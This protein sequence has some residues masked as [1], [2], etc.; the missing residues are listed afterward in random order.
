TGR[1]VVRERRSRDT[2]VVAPDRT[3]VAV[4][5][6]VAGERAVDRGHDVAADRAAL[7]E[8]T[9]VVRERRVRDLHGAGDADG[10]AAFVVGRVGAVA[11]ERAV[12]D[13][14]VSGGDR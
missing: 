10:A 1:E 3:A 9:A 5:G 7:T 14:R 12:G 13:R 6:A 11:G 2:N 8:P 4:I